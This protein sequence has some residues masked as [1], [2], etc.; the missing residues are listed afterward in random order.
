MVIFFSSCLLVFLELIRLYWRTD[1]VVVFLL[2]WR[3][4][5]LVWRQDGY[6]LLFLVPVFYHLISQYY[7][8][9]DFSW[10]GGGQMGLLYVLSYG[11]EFLKY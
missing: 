1:L 5:S 10:L 7:V 8:G 3:V 2:G 9:V 4:V 6:C 11:I